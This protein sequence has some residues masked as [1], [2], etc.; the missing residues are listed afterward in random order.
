MSEVVGGFQYTPFGVFPLDTAVPT[1]TDTMPSALPS[2]VAESVIAQLDRAPR[3][4]SVSLS[5][6]LPEPARVPRDKPVTGRDILRMARARVK[7]I[8]KAL[9]A[10]PTLEAERAE[11]QRLI[12]AATKKATPVRSIKSA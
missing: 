6:R 11:M 2:V 8:D 3:V 10:V 1:A 12:D 9:R 7:E 4:E 5:N